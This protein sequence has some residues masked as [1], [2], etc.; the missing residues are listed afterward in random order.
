MYRL[1]T[2][3]GVVFDN[4]KF[5]DPVSKLPP[6][7]QH[8]IAPYWTHS[9]LTFIRPTNQ[10]SAAT[11]HHSKWKLLKPS[12]SLVAPLTESCDKCTTTVML[13]VHLQVQ[14]RYVAPCGFTI[15][16]LTE[17]HLVWIHLQAINMN[18]IQLC[19]CSAPLFDCFVCVLC[20]CSATS[21]K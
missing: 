15:S 19:S 16:I 8:A 14:C 18:N 2:N 3:V 4:R 6:L 5:S 1:V 10:N 7:K 20:F 13:L 21:S 11:C 17:W 12:C 9:R